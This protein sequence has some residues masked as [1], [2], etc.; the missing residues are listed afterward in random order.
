MQILPNRF[1]TANMAA[2]CSPLS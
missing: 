1:K 2:R